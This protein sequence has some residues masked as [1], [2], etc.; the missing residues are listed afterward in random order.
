VTAPSSTN[1]AVLVV[2]D[3]TDLLATYRRLLG[4]VG[5]RV[6]TASTCREGLRALEAERFAAV[7]VDVRLPDGDGLDVVRA[8][9]AMAPPAPAMV[10]TG[11]P[12][13]HLRELALAAGATDFF[14]K[15]FNAA[16]LAAR[17]TTLARP[18]TPA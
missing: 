3:E 16:T 9:R 8:A 10:V 5:L 1:G 11:F 14:A 18:D 17:V 13:R 15:P 12:S 4:R 6:V 7:I 2:E